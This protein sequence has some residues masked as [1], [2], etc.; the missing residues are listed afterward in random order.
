VNHFIIPSNLSIKKIDDLFLR[1]SQDS[2]DAVIVSPQKSDL[3]NMK[4][5]SGHSRVRGRIKLI[6]EKA[7]QHN[8]NVEIGGWMLSELV[9]RKCFLF[10]KELFRMEKGK[11]IKQVHFCPTNPDTINLIQKE[12]RKLFSSFLESRFRESS[13]PQIKTFHLWPEQS[14]ESVWCNCPSCRAFSFAEQNIIAVNAAADVLAETNPHAKIS[15]IEIET[16]ND[17]KPSVKPRENMFAINREDI[18]KLI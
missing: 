11:R 14:K 2:V 17:E 9:P 12:A 15:Y 8:I 1:A 10:H 16:N 3:R 13:F 5:L 18:E 6:F 4:K 7:A